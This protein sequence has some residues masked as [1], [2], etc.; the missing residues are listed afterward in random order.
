MT[1]KTNRN[2]DLRTGR[3][4]ALKTLGVIGFSA[5]GA[6][7]PVGT[8]RGSGV[9]N[10]CSM[11]DPQCGG[12]GGDGPR[13]WRER[14]EYQF[15]LGGRLYTG[16]MT[17]SFF[18]YDAVAIEGAGNRSAYWQVPIEICSNGLAYGT[19]GNLAH[20]INRSEVSVSRTGR[21]RLD[22]GINEEYIGSVDRIDPSSQYDYRDYAGDIIEFGM[23]QLPYIGTAMS[24]QET[25]E[26]MLN[27]YTHETD[28]DDTVERFF[29]YNGNNRS[30]SEQYSNWNHIEIKNFFNG[31]DSC[32]LAIEDWVDLERGSMSNTVNL[33]V[34]APALD[35]SRQIDSISQEEIA[36]NEVEIH[37]V[38]EV[39]KNPT[40]YGLRS[41]D[42][43]HLSPNDIL[44][45]APARITVSS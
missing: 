28:A 36:A 27:K 8:A 31:G 35:P 26:S 13:A 7:L 38:R 2:R 42:I 30:R 32:D 34:S 3:R 22:A 14:D 33:A 21:G 10:P 12:G 29:N 25:G 41:D 5:V 40:T 44:Y 37:L 16:E 6:S 18:E 19:D 39:R 20:W 11:G 17:T 45:F 24:I 43:D 1:D 15:G 23:G 9:V 4:G